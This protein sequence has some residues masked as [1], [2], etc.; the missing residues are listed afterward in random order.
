MRILVLIVTVLIGIATLSP[1][2]AEIFVIESFE[3][4]D[5]GLA[6]QTPT[7]GPGLPWLEDNLD[8]PVQV[9]SG[10]I[11]LNHGPFRRSV[12]TPLPL[13]GPSGTIYVRFD[14]R[15]P[16]GQTVN[17]DSRGLY[18][19][20]F[21]R[22]GTA[23]GRM[24]V[25]SPNAGG[26]FAI[27][28]NG[29]C[30][31]LGAGA[32]WPSDLDFDTTYRIIYSYSFEN[33][34]QESRL[35]LDPVDSNSPSIFHSAGT[36]GTTP[37]DSFSFNQL[38][39][40]VGNQ[41]LDN[42]VIA[43]NFDEALAGTVP[44]TTITPSSFVVT[45]GNYAAGNV[46]SLANSDNSDLSIRRSTSDIQSRCEFEVAGMSPVALPSLIEISLEGSVFARTQVSQTVE[47]FD[48]DAGIWE[49]V[50]TGVAARF[51][52]TTVSAEATGDLSRYVQAGSLS[53]KAR[54]RYQSL[55]ARQQFTSNTDQFTWTFGH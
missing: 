53:V 20:H 48:F 43:D 38:N 30:S 10:G 3:H 27:A 22:D 52:D 54:I 55:N 34:T 14:V 46:A 37:V 47:L 2:G 45:R 39:D 9:V 33:G 18:F 23:H 11:V 17:P 8:N 44:S 36:A 28:V 24:G 42:L 40:Y 29:C 41:R 50:Y 19:A 31:D 4:P 6:G 51:S 13:L 35:W 49:E 7:P 12:R 15:F 1:A 16:S 26:D 5:G 32:I 25:L 21:G